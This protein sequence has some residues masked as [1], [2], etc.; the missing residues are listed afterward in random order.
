M[1]RGSYEDLFRADVTLHD[2]IVE[3]SGN[4]RLAEFVRGLNDQIQR[5]RHISATTPGRPSNVPLPNWPA[6]CPRSTSATLRR[7]RSGSGGRGSGRAGRPG[8]PGL[9][10]LGGPARRAVASSI[11]D[12]V[13]TEQN[14]NGGEAE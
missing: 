13:G 12:S 10:L 5:I 14:P 1:P 8:Q 11:C 2:F 3:Q 7:T 4:E 6:A 9:G